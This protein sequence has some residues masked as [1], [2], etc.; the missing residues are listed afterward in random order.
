MG[1]DAADLPALWV[2]TQQ[3]ACRC[4]AAD[5]QWLHQDFHQDFRILFEDGHGHRQSKA[6]DVITGKKRNCLG[7][8]KADRVIFPMDNL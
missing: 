4:N 3:P 1:T 6:G 7:P 2:P 5:L 8:S